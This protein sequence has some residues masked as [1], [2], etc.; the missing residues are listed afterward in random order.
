M[1]FMLHLLIGIH[2]ST[3]AVNSLKSLKYGINRCLRK[4]GHAYVTKNVNFAQ[5]MKDFDLACLELT[6]WKGIH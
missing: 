1:V 5:C 2:F 4:A 3:C 6:E